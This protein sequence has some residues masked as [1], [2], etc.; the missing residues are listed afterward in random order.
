M[1]EINIKFYGL[2]FGNI[3]QAYVTIYDNNKKIFEGKTYN[4]K[5][6]VCLEKNK[7]YKINAKTDKETLKDYF[8]VGKENKYYFTFQNIIYTNNRSI[9]F[10][11]QDYF[12][13]LPIERGELIVWQNK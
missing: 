2:G 3:N 9:T 1:K 10:I 6:N 5:I 4:N 8:Y 7:I 12:Y 11:L 13:N